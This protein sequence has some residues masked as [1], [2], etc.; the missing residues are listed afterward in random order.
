MLH[1][2]RTEN[3]HK[4]LKAAAILLS[5]KSQIHAILA[6]IASWLVTATHG[7]HPKRRHLGHPHSTHWRGRPIASSKT[8]SSHSRH[9]WCRQSKRQQLSIH[10]LRQKTHSYQYYSNVQKMKTM[11]KKTG[12]ITYQ[13]Q[14]NLNNETAD[15]IIRY[16]LQSHDKNYFNFNR[17]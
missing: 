6:L 2:I 1:P 14:I 4:N 16:I 13:W 5:I 10:V 15:I 12:F 17:K 8:W 11:I 3:L 7:W 9:W